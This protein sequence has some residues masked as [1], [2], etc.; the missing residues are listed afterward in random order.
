MICNCFPL[1][2]GEASNPSVL[3]LVICIYARIQEQVTNAMLAAI[4]EQEM[5]YTP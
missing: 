3:Q 2:Y 5:V 1:V 4:L